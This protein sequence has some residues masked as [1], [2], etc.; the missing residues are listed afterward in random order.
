MRK[1]QK[2]MRD[3]VESCLNDY[4][5][6]SVNLFSYD[7]FFSFF[8]IRYENLVENCLNSHRPI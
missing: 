7:F 8:N 1:K 4:Y 5:F 3:F 6:S 2:L